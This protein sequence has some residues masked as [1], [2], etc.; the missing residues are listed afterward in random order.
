MRKPMISRSGWKLALLLAI[1]IGALAVGGFAYSA[2]GPNAQLVGQDRA[3]GGGTYQ[4]GNT[5]Q[6][7]NF[8]I[9]AHAS[10][11]A[12]YGNVEYAG[13]AVGAFR[14]EQVTCLSVVG[15]KATIGGVINA[16][17][18]PAF[19]GLFFL[20]VVQDN[21]SPSSGTPDTAAFQALGPASDPTW[22]S[23][24]PHSCPTPDN[25]INTFQLDLFPLSGGDIVVQQAGK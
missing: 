12:A 19:V 13:A 17:N 9:D 22:P 4:P 15:N 23:G 3:Y 24:F 14:E 21:G 25:A 10:G 5:T 11:A 8:A 1:A 18:N 2:D 6:P 20:W 16:S 7:R